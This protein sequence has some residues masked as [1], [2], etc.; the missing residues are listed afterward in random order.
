VLE[1]RDII[2][3]SAAAIDSD[4]YG[5]GGTAKRPPAYSICKKKFTNHIITL[6]W[7]N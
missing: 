6:Q 7:C 4:R 5:A 2:C 3:P 1:S